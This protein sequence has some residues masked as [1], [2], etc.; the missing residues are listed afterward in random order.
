[1]KFGVLQF[2]CR[3]QRRIKL[4]EIC[5]RALDR[6]GKEVALRAI[7]CNGRVQWGVGRGHPARLSRT[8]KVLPHI[9]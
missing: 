5:N 1:M 3:P 6:L 2:F 8:G 4:E 9:Q 7:L